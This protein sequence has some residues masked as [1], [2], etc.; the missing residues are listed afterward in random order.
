MT[1]LEAKLKANLSSFMHKMSVYCKVQLT[2]QSGLNQSP[3][4]K[5][6]LGTK[7]TS[8]QLGQCPR[9]AESFAF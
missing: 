8:A 9:W 1:I 2:C 7:Q 4:H 3:Q 6:P 5:Q